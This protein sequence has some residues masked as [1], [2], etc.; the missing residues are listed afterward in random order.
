MNVEEF[1]RRI[2]ELYLPPVGQFTLIDVPEI[3]FA[4]VDGEGDPEGDGSAAAAK[5][6]YSV[7]HL[8]KPLVK[9]RAGRSFLEPPLECLCWADDEKDFVERKK[10]KWRWRVMVPFVDWITQEQFG[11]AVAKAEK[12]RGPAPSSLRLENLHE[13]RS[14]QI[15]HVGDYS[16]IGAV[17]D[18]LYS[19]YLPEKHLRPNGYYHEIY[20]NDPARTAPG[21]RRVVI[22]QPVVEMST[23]P[24]ALR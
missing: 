15:L 6:L 21:L 16:E 14:V 7:V 23:E 3:R 12:K 18:M 11:D 13:G 4:V 20:L 17:C 9:E 24:I 22:R 10:D 2:R 5:W 1:H 8:V 19:V